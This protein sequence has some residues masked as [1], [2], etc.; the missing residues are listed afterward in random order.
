VA[1]AKPPL[2]QVI[3]LVVYAPVGAFVAAR[4]QLPELIEKGRKQ[5]TNQLSLARFVGQFAVTQG[6]KE[7]QRLAGQVAQ[8]ASQM[9]RRPPGAPGA[10]GAPEGTH[11]PPPAAS[12]NSPPAGAPVPEPDVAVGTL[13]IPGYDA[14]SASQVVQRLAGLSSAEL[15][16]VEAYEASTRGRRTIL[17]KVAQ[18]RSD[19]IS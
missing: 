4:D 16:A 5:V 12:S 13:A 2:E 18:L 19:R 14:L 10:P 9:F 15:D 1:E 8:Q 6:Q 7:L 3:D 11:P 17:A